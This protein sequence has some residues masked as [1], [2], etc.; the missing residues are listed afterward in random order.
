MGFAL[1]G[2]GGVKMRGS[3]QDF[4]WKTLKTSATRSAS[5]GWDV[6]LCG[7]EGGDSG[8]VLA[9]CVLSRQPREL[10]LSFFWP[11]ETIFVLLVALVSD[12]PLEW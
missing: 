9:I 3:A 4:Y 11:Q 2:R 1:L 12:C 10:P 8:L 6:G 7:R 5:R